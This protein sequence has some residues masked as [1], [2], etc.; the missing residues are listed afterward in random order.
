M[1]PDLGE[2]A[3]VRARTPSGLQIRKLRE[4][5]GLTQPMLVAKVQLPGWDLSR[6]TLA[7]IESQ[8]RWVADCELVYLA[9]AWNVRVDALLP[10]RQEAVKAIRTFFRN[11][12]SA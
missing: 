8:I 12:T 2:L 1:K 5:R 11:P 6:E 10:D 4:Q 7:K 3:D 9:Q